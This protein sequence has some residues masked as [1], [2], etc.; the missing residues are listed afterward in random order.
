MAWRNGKWVYEGLPTFRSTEEIIKYGIREEK[1]WEKGFDGM[2]GMYY[3]YLTQYKIKD[4]YEGYTIYPN[5]RQADHELIFP[6]LEKVMKNNRDG[7]WITSRGAGKSTIIDGPAVMETAINYPGSQT[8]LTADSVTNI[9]TAFEEKLKPCYY[10][11][12]EYFRPSMSGIW[13]NI[14]GKQMPVV[15]FLNR[16]K[17]NGK[18]QEEGLGSVIRGLDT[19]ARGEGN[20]VE[21]QGVKLFVIDEMFKHPHVESLSSKA[22][23][24]TT[25]GRRK[26]GSVLYVGSCSDVKAVGMEAAKTLWNGADTLGIDPLFVPA[27]WLFPEYEI[28]DDKGKLTGRYESVVDDRGIIDIK[29]AE[30]C[31][32]R[33]RGILE[34]L[35]NKRFYWEEILKFPLSVDELFDIETDGW[36][37]IETIEQQKIQK[38]IVSIAIQAKNY[39]KCDQPAVV[40]LSPESGRPILKLT[41]DRELSTLFIFDT[42]KE[43][44]TYGMGTDPIFG[45]TSN[46]EGSDHTSVIKNLDTNQYVAALI[47]R[48]DNMSKLTKK[49]IWLQQLYNDAKNLMEKNA[50]GACR[51]LYSEYGMLHMLSKTP[52]RFRP[53]G[54]SVD[55]GLNKDIHTAD[56]LHDLVRQYVDNNIHLIFF[57]RFFEEFSGF[58]H[59]NSD[60]MSAMAMCEA[61]HEDYRTLEKRNSKIPIYGGAQVS[62]S[63][64][65]NGN[66]VMTSSSTSMTDFIGRDGSL[67]IGSLWEQE[68]LKNGGKTK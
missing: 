39:E 64:L 43:E 14:V 36:W 50:A 37:D 56:T 24:L 16:K 22:G 65:P 67:D 62:F 25:R 32:K 20:K 3:K 45:N 9:Q 2:S 10:G 41:D 60:F 53:K 26:V 5:Y 52:R 27:S 48:N 8:I 61:L 58:P 21:G 33:N 7:I 17:V 35:P 30:E 47:E 15:Q 28:Y 23:P 40:F 66:R 1:R 54:G 42:P 11:L 13:P 19:V 6:W 49:M 55:Y 31:I 34:K 44:C 29:K 57:Q 4:R 18:W 63:T 12:S 38:N 59:K 46:K 68:F 51:A